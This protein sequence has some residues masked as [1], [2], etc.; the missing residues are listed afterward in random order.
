MI[1]W[2][3]SRKTAHLPKL[4]RR[5]EDSL[6][7]KAAEPFLPRS[8]RG[9]AA[10]YAPEGPPPDRQPGGDVPV[11]QWSAH[12]DVP[13]VGQ[14]HRGEDGR[15]EGDVVQ[16]VDDEG[17][18]VDKD[19][20]RPLEGP[21]ELEWKCWAFTSVN[22]M[23][24]NRQELEGTAMTPCSPLPMPLFSLHPMSAVK[25]VG[26]SRPNTFTTN[27]FFWLKPYMA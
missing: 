10:S 4:W 11:V 24:G 26:R 13:L 25:L 20:A 23:T 1:Y 6:E 21:A 16:R 15:A 9:L 8:G 18:E 7:K 12:G 5:N 3:L 17:E 22:G 14:G 2:P 19:R 27:P